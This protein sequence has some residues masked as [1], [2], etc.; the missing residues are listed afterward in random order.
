M[1]DESTGLTPDQQAS[2]DTLVQD[3]AAEGKIALAEARAALILSAPL[4]I[5][6]SAEAAAY[7]R[8][9]DTVRANKKRQS[10]KH[11]RNQIILDLADHGVKAT[12]ATK[13]RIVALLDKA[14]GAAV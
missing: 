1:P 7:D 10:V 4:V 5:R 3:V 8:A 14:I 9:G 11:V 2:F 6:W 13:T 12:N